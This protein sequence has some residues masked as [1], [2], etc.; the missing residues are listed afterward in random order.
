MANPFRRAN[1]M[2]LKPLLAALVVVAAV[3]A[4]AV[5]FPIKD[6]KAAISIARAVCS[7]KASP[8]AKWHADLDTT[9]TIWFAK[10]MNGQWGVHIPVNGPSPAICYVEGY[11]VPS[12]TPHEKGRKPAQP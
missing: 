4:H 1:V 7:K 11:F 6:A 2:R 10:T 5:T 12:G 3:P 8:T 9:G